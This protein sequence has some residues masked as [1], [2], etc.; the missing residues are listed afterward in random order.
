MRRTLSVILLILGAIIA[1]E[2]SAQTSSINTYSPYTFYG[3]GDFAMQGNTTQQ[4]M[5]GA[6]VAY[7][8]TTEINFLNPASLGN[9]PRRTVLFNFGMSGDNVYSEGVEGTTSYNTFNISNISLQMSLYDGMGL[10][11]SM[12]PLTNIGYY[13]DVEDT[14]P[15]I[16][17]NVGDVRYV[18]MGEGGI[19]QFK[20]GYG[21]KITKH[22]SVGVES[23]YYHGNINRYYT[24]S[25][26]STIQPTSTNN[27]VGSSTEMISDIGFKFGVQASPIMN[28]SR[29]LTFAATYHM[30][31]DLNS[32]FE[33]YIY[34]S[35]N[36]VDT[37]VYRNTSGVVEMPGTTTI[38]MS[39]QTRK[40]SFNADYKYQD[41]S[42][43]DTGSDDYSYFNN[44]TL[45]VGAEYT[46]NRT[47]IRSMLKRWTYRAGVRTG[48]Y[49]IEID[50]ERVKDT[51]ITLGLGI[52]VK[53]GS[54]STINLGA[55]L[56][57]RGAINGGLIE[58]KY[59]KLS[60]G[61]AMFAEDYWF[62]KP[63]YD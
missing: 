51:A 36:F 31:G 21:S 61:L 1:V 6:G 35:S 52:P 11:F 28:S 40:F 45:S 3:L 54:L 12:T 23:I 18:Y 26:T 55:E 17:A 43:I 59:I 8:S 46:P 24:A 57:K 22:V 50:G 33:E 30:G 58:E 41:W 42:D 20:L 25:I 5:G 10:N 47:D 19:T 15:S 39:Y 14:D 60:V 9:M 16:S 62:V 34:T 49:Y 56:G 32:E 38:G 27:T 44:N 53:Y 48:N 29:M 37:V 7:R 13:I 4:A 63:K 2:V